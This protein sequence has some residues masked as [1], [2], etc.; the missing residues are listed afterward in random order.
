VTWLTAGVKSAAGIIKKLSYKF[1]LKNFA[2][3]KNHNMAAYEF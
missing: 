3:F 2:L 1:R